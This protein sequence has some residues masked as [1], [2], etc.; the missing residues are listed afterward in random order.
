MLSHEEQYVRLADGF[1]EALSRAEV[2]GD[3]VA[4]EISASRPFRD[5]Y[6][7]EL[8]VGPHQ[9]LVL[10]TSTWGG[11]SA[12]GGAPDLFRRAMAEL[13]RDE[14]RVLAAIHPN[15][16]HGHGGWQLTHWLRPHLDAGLLL[17]DPAGDTWKAAVCAADVFLGDHGSLTLYAA[18]QG[19]P[20]LLGSF[21]DDR[22]APGSPMER[23]GRQLPRV[24][25]VR[26]LEPQL[27]AAS[28]V[29]EA[30]DLVTSHPGEALR[31]LRALSY[32]RL[33]LP[34]PPWPIAPRAVPLPLRLPTV[35]RSP[36]TPAHL[37][38]ARVD[39]DTVRLRRY[40]AHHQRHQD[41]HLRGAH[42]VAEDGDPDTQVRDR[43]R[44]LVTRRADPEK[45]F[46]GRPDLRVVARPLPEG[47]EVTVQ[48]GPRLVVRA[49]EEDPDPMLVGATV[50]A[51]LDQGAGQRPP[52]PEVTVDLGAARSAL[53]LVPLVEEGP[54]LA[55]ADFAAQSLVQDEG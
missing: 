31:R 5:M 7:R 44:V 45:L 15:A 29:A 23:I 16:W 3:S 33:E 12:L 48:D 43:A 18:D 39:G 9:K 26:P 27:R 24:S 34:E 20:G 21:D 41:A 17:P 52:P 37:V 38:T 28:T 32:R 47:C 46:R 10:I 40:P 25:A 50:L 22:V 49:A 13:P 8:G 42:L 35:R 4:D 2:I 6:R 11:L 19:V 30:G 54:N 51:L 36:A 14:Y 55:D 1:P 53:R